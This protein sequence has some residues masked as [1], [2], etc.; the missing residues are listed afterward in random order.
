MRSRQAPR[1]AAVLA[2]V[3]YFSLQLQGKKNTPE[4]GVE[5]WSGSQVTD[6]YT[7]ACYLL[8]TKSRAWLIQA[9]TLTP[10]DNL[11]NASR[12]CSGLASANSA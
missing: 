8:A 5:N 10:R 7:V 4:A 9:S 12:T 2:L 11:P 1:K 6:L 3:G